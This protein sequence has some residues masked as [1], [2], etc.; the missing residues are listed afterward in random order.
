MPLRDR[1]E[2]RGRLD[3]V[4]SS[5]FPSEPSQRI[6]EL[7]RHKQLPTIV[8]RLNHKIKCHDQYIDTVKQMNVA[9]GKAINFLSEGRRKRLIT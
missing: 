2:V 9:V 6:Q 7:A 5:L 3:E 8:E 4:L 1:H